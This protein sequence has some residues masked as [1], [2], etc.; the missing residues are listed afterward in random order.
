MQEP[1]FHVARRLG[2]D[3][4]RCRSGCA[5]TGHHSP[6]IYQT[7]CFADAVRAGE[8]VSACAVGWGWTAV[9]WTCV[10]EWTGGGEVVMVLWDWGGDVWVWAVYDILCLSSPFPRPPPTCRPICFVLP[11]PPP[12][13]VVPQPPSPEPAPPHALGCSP[14]SLPPHLTALTAFPHRDASSDVQC[15]T[16]VT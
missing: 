7:L 14:A 16:D 4:L 12:G 13:L 2:A 3:P 8:T 1:C 15:E 11:T 6:H 5:G 10:C 9:G